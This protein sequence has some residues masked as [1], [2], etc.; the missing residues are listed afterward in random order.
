MTQLIMLNQVEIAGH[1]INL[2]RESLAFLE[3][4]R[5]GETGISSHTVFQRNKIIGK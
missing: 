4:T 3:G 1:K 5:R 2:K